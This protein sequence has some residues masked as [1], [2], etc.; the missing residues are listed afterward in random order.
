MHQ[1]L[2]RLAQETS[3]EKRL[4]LL[5]KVSDMYFEE[6][7]SRSDAEE[8]LFGEIVDRILDA[9]AKPE[10]VTVSNT[11]AIRPKFPHAAAVKLAGDEDIAVARPVIASSPVLNENDL[12]QLATR[13]SQEHL[14]AIADRPGLSENVTDVLV[15]RGDQRVARTVSANHD[16]RLSPSG[17]DGLLAKAREDIDLRAVLV[18]RPDL[19][20]ATVAKLLPLVSAELAARLAERGYDVANALPP[21]MVTTVGRRLTNALRE[22]RSNIRDTATL[23][24]AVRA[25]EL[26]LDEAAFML[27]QG[28]RLID[29]AA[30]L[31]AFAN[32]DRDYLFGLITRGQLQA[33]MILFRALGLG[34][35][36]LERVLTLRNQKHGGGAAPASLRAEFLAIDA[37]AAR[38][39]LRFS[40]VRRA[41]S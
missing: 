29:L 13:G 6:V 21:D 25:G 39:T 17:M 41:A 20:Q 1:E 35:P 40:H 31:S 5:R 27:A 19:S 3:S 4:E 28:G 33:V 2:K 38:R 7:G 24:E 14:H 8:Y 15:D 37:G 16:A 30:L 22:R 32:V 12:V 11:I 23:V 9:I 26:M 36:T 34:W 18:E 10:K